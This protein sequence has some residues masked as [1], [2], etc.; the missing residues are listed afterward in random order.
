MTSNA[1]LWAKNNCKSS[2]WNKEDSVVCIELKQ[3]VSFAPRSTIDLP[4]ASPRFLI[5]LVPPHSPS[6]PVDVQTAQN[7]SQVESVQRE[8]Q[9]GPVTSAGRYI[10]RAGGGGWRWD[11]VPQRAVARARRGVS[12][13][14]MRATHH[15]RLVGRAMSLHPIYAVA[16]RL[17]QRPEIVTST[18]GARRRY[19]NVAAYFVG[20]SWALELL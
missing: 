9:P 15:S 6:S 12:C 18:S 14:S 3:A 13:W 8:G 7:G 16:S 4:L 10:D 20:N 19:A 2:V 11:G 5:Y 1:L 17:D